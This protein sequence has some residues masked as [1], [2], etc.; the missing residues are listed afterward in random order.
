MKQY[1]RNRAYDVTFDFRHDSTIAFP[2]FEL[3]PAPPTS[4]FLVDLTAR[5]WEA[6]R[7]EGKI[8]ILF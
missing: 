2:A 3:P 6:S 4:S 5:V 8:P 7:K 1:D